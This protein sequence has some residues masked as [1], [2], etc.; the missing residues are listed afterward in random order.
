MNYHTKIMLLALCITPHMLADVQ[1]D[2]IIDFPLRGSSFL[3]FRSQSTNAAQ[4]LV[5]WRD[6]INLYGQCGWYGAFAVTP[7]YGQSYRPAR[8]AEYFFGVDT[9]RVTGSQVPNRKDTDMLADYFG[10]SPDFVSTVQLVPYMTN[11]YVDFNIYAGYKDLFFRI[12]APVVWTST[13]IS[14]KE[15]VEQERV[16][17]PF[18]PFYMASGPVAPGAASWEQA[19]RGGITFGDVVEGINFGRISCDSQHRR[20][21]SDIQAAFGWNFYNRDWAHMGLEVRASF[22]TGTRPTSNYLFEPIVG[23]GKHFELG[24]GF[25]SHALVWER[26]CYQSVSV[27]TDINVMHLFASRQRRS[28]DFIPLICPD[29]SNAYRTASRYI[30][31][32]EF[33]EQGIYTGRSF[34]AIN[35][36]TLE[37]KV[38][39][40]V[41][42]DL[43]IM[44]AF[45][46]NSFGLDLGYGA[47]IRSREKIKLLEGL[48]ERRYA[49]KGI[50]NV[51][52]GIGNLPSNATQSRATIYGNEFIF[53]AEVAD[54]NPPVFVGTCDL[55]LDS[56]AN[57]STFTHKLFWNLSYAWNPTDTRSVVPF[58]GV[59]GEVDF[60]SLRPRRYIRPNKNS[61]SEWL[62]WFKG[63]M[64]F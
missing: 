46:S 8:I 47:W 57:P 63:G 22:P 18:P 64:G 40:D 30:L 13:R 21:L 54:L 24:I 56:A 14:V 15:T 28:F 38:W 33:D 52:T 27:Y 35:R 2:T 9:F 58:V 10:L 17:I 42:M 7:T 61:V 29:F 34:P 37:S 36:T 12:H 59:G 39:A 62:L 5:G 19:L 53:Q 32:K 50:Q 41:Q 16:T 44:I 23:N 20:G 60:E 49:L 43:A 45:T 31:L 4:E 51:T 25:T 1:V 3:S 6:L 48:P 26:D 11:G 55:D